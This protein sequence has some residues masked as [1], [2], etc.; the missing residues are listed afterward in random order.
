MNMSVF[1]KFIAGAIAIGLVTTLILPKRQ[2]PQVI[3]A[4]TNFFRGVLSTAMATGK[5][6]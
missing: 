2:T 6:V 3:N 4:G 5:Q 1:E